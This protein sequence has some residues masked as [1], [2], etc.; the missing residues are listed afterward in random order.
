[1]VQLDELETLPIKSLMS[2]TVFAAVAP[3]LSVLYSAL[4][5]EGDE[6]YAQSLRDFKLMMPQHLGLRNRPELCLQSLLLFLHR[7]KLLH[8]LTQ[9]LLLDARLTVSTS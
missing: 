6:L 8:H 5:A 4:C 1:M 9:C 7:T 3:T 2:E